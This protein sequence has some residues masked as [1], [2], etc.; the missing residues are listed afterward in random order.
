[1]KVLLLIPKGYYGFFHTMKETFE[2]LGGEVDSL[3]FRGVVKGWEDKVNGQVGRFPDRFRR[4][5]ENYFFRRINEFYLREY[6]ERQPD[7]GDDGVF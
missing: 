7:E 2:H 3:N 5:W 6:D 1:M 4:K